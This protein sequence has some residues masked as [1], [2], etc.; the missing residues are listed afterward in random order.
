MVVVTVTALAPGSIV[1]VTE[2]AVIAAPGV[3]VVEEDVVTVGTVTDVM[4]VLPT[5]VASVLGV[6]AVLVAYG[7]VK[8]EAVDMTTQDAVVVEDGASD[9]PT[10]APR[11]VSAGLRF[12]S[13]VVIETSSGV[14][15][16]ID[17]GVK[18]EMP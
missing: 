18:W 14:V 10:I 9:A 16:G 8:V 5:A 3:A 12:G 13:G 2:A 1:G 4:E 6:T 17:K 11:E 7:G 15:D